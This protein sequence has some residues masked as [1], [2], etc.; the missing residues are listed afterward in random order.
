VE[1]RWL[2]LLTSVLS[3]AFALWLAIRFGE[4]RRPS[5]ALW[6]IGLAA[7]GLS[8]GLEAVSLWNPQTYRW[9]YLSGAIGVAAYLGAGAAYL[10]RSRVFAWLVVACVAAGALPALLSGFLQ[11]ALI[12]LAAAV[13]L[14]IVNV[15]TADAFAEA[16]TI[17][18]LL[19]SLLA[20][21][22]VLT[23]PVDV[24]LLPQANDIATGQALD[25][26]TRLLSP[27][28]NIP[29]AAALLLGAL[30]SLVHYARERNQLERVAANALIALG[31][32]V[33]SLTSSLT[34]FGLSADFYVGQLIGVLCLLAGFAITDLARGGSSPG[35]ALPGPPSR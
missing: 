24:A 16:V 11:I 13:A 19:G 1:V 18:L 32:F 31:A 21:L 3:V 30:A 22:E 17:V 6:A 26:Q 25:A 8:S 12:G 28:F 29:G 15:R 10:H 5:F 20:A 14:V 33:P 35:A 27:L 23:A 4:G 34:R 2:P 7:Y 9:W